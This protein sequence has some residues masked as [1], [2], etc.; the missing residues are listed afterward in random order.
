ME[1]YATTGSSMTSLQLKCGDNVQIIRQKI[2]NNNNTTSKKNTRPRS[3][4]N[5]IVTFRNPRGFDVGRIAEA[6]ADWMSK[7]LD[8]S[9]VKFSATVLSCPTPLR[10]SMSTFPLTGLTILFLPL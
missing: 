8:L 7:A 5:R 10:L 2:D 4:E 3:K 9:I 1:G 6:S